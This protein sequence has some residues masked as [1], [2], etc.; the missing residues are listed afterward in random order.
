MLYPLVNFI[1]TVTGISLD[2]FLGES[3]SKSVKIYPGHC[4]YHII[5]PPTS[6][7]VGELMGYQ[8]VISLVIFGPGVVG[9]DL[10]NGKPRGGGG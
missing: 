4:T 10:A 6:G 3:H 8:A 9:V 1:H 5:N 2:L 7:S